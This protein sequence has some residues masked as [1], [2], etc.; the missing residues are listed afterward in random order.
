MDARG[1]SPLVPEATKKIVAWGFCP[2][3]QIQAL[4]WRSNAAAAA[5]TGISIKRR[6]CGVVN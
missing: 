3:A 5:A 1:T 2:Q 6:K 4:R